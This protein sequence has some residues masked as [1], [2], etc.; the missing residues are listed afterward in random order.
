MEGKR[1]WGICRSLLEGRS[2]WLLRGRLPACRTL[3]WFVDRDEALEMQGYLRSGL[4]V[5][6]SFKNL[7]ARIDQAS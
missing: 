1:T 4:S 3:L 2:G 5:E 7:Y 6:A